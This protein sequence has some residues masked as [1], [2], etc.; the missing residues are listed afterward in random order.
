M[1]LRSDKVPANGR[2]RADGLSAK[3]VSVQPRD[4]GNLRH[5]DKPK[6]CIL[7]Q[8]VRTH[9]I[10]QPCI[11]IQRVQWCVPLSL[12]SLSLCSL[13]SSPISH[14][15]L[16]KTR[17]VSIGTLSLPLCSL[18]L[19]SSNGQQQLNQ[20]LYL[21]CSNQRLSLSLLS[22]S[23]ISLLSSSPISRAAAPSH[24]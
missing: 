4:V 16:T 24:S 11:R 20:A 21:N 17:S 10:I 23:L 8:R 5:N 7:S 13:C 2:V 12:L 22:L 19:S 3:V 6:N 18:S 1:Y 15:F 9:K 14:F